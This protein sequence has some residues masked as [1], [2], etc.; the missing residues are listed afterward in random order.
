MFYNRYIIEKERYA[1]LKGKKVDFGPDAIN[2]LFGLE[3]CKIGHA[4]FKSLQ[5][6]DL[7]DA[8]KRVVWFG[9]K[10]DITTIG[11]Y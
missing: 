2:E 1:M 10:W 5:E 11:K 7:E 9:T 3:A 8:S 4:I 6:R